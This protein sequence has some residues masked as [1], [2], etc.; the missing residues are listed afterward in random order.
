MI[1][2]VKDNNGKVVI[3]R[4]IDKEDVLL[5]VSVKSN[6]SDK[7]YTLEQVCGSYH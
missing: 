1:I 3:E 6:E 7:E 4:E 5:K 2:S